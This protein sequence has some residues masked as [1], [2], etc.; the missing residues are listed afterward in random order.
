MDIFHD[1]AVGVV[2]VWLLE[3]SQFHGFAEKLTIAD[4]P[5]PPGGLSVLSASQ[6]QM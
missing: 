1:V 5:A 6:G 2:F 3:T 4:H